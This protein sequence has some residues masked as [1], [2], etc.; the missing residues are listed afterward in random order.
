[1]KKS[2]VAW[3]SFVCVLPCFSA[4]SRAAGFDSVVSEWREMDVVAP[5]DR[6]DTRLGTAV[7]GDGRV[8]ARRGASR[9]A[10]G[11]QQLVLR[12]HVLGVFVQR[13]A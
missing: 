3:A 9:S 12:G 2:V 8:A 11:L 10:Q 13:L 7:G 5:A 6:V 4:E 1:M